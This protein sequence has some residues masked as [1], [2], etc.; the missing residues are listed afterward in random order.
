M[1][2]SG[3]AFSLWPTGALRDREGVGGDVVTAE[4]R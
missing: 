2:F 1:S 4:L 3:V